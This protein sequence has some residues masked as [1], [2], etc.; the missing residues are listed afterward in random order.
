[1]TENIYPKLAQGP[2]TPATYVDK[3]HDQSGITYPNLHRR[4]DDEATPLDP[5]EVQPDQ[6]TISVSGVDS[7]RTTKHIVHTE[8]STDSDTP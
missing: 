3:V 8:D 2:A 6:Y 5:G 4:V 7:Y 1:M